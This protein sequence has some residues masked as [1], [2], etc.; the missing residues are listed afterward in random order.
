MAKINR[1]KARKEYTCSKCRKKILV[2]EEYL[3]GVPYMRKPIIRCLSCGLSSWELSSSEYIQRVGNLVENWE[4]DYAIDEDIFD[5]IASEI[6]EIKDECEDRYEN[7]PDQ[8]KEGEAG[9]LLEERIEALEG[10]YDELTSRDF[11]TI[12][13]DAF[14]EYDEEEAKEMLSAL[15]VND[16]IEASFFDISATANETDCDALEELLDDIKCSVETEVEDILSELEY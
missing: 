16:I 9:T 11:G 2:G 13:S 1:I 8:L 10:V 4:K 14:E 3:K 7:I 5:S 15:G 12:I 6:E